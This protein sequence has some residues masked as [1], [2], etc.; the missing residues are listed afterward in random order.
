M[1]YSSIP[2][3]SAPYSTS[4]LDE[5]LP[6]TVEDLIADQE[7][8]RT[9][10]FIATPYDPVTDAE[11]EVRASLGIEF[12]ILDGKHWPA[13]LNTA[14]N[15][16]VQLFDGSWVNPQGRTSIG[17][18]ELLIGSG[19]YDYL[20]DYI[21]GGR[22]F[23]IYLGAEHFDFS[24][25][26]VVV[27]GVVKNVSYDKDR[28][29]L[30]VGGK[31][32]LLENK[33]QENLIGGASS[34]GGVQ[35]IAYGDI[36]NY[37]PIL[38]DA[39]RNIYQIHDG[40]I[41][42][43]DGPDE[44][45]DCFDG[46]A[47]L[48]YAGVYSDITSISVPPG[49]FAVQAVGAFIRLGAPPAKGVVTVDFR[50]QIKREGISYSIDYLSHA[51]DILRDVLTYRTDL[52]DDDLD[53]GS[54]EYIDTHFRAQ[55]NY[56]GLILQDETAVDVINYIMRSLSGAWTFTAS[57]KL[58]IALFERTSSIGTITED[59]IVKISREHTVSPPWKWKVGYKRNWTVQTEDD[60]VGSASTE[61]RK[62]KLYEYFYTTQLRQDIKDM[63]PDAPVYEIDTCL[64]I[65]SA[66]PA[67]NPAGA[68]IVRSL[69]NIVNY[70]P[71]DT[72]T[73]HHP[74]VYKLITV[75]QQ[76]RYEVGEMIT[77]IHPRF[78]LSSGKDA[79]IMEI[80]ESTS[81]G[82]TGLTC[83]A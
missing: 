68:F 31:E 73:Y 54:F 69:A 53:L 81:S 61:R 64:Q 63:Y 15:Y 52:T 35:P 55:Y 19:D 59:D 58:K 39:D 75:R 60:F 21:W 28:F 29:T 2:F 49:S 37:S 9:Y 46:G 11:I 20:N 16:N 38:V 72:T 48:T 77:I 70:T 51:T 10:L 3:S 1:R 41:Q 13:I 12:P 65:S 30:T 43:L 8:P 83:W 44:L 80:S 74:Q 71:P 42:L 23:K 56:S 50:G 25:Y 36:I 57:G 27:S 67:V 32:N 14:I 62:G 7:F 4:S 66:E 82:Q 18:I 26:R 79:L 24:T 40:T 22:T 45:I 76:F 78:G 33:V 34:G 47:P 5:S 6:A 17:N